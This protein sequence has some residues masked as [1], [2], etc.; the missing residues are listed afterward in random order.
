MS[1]TVLMHLETFPFHLDTQFIEVQLCTVFSF[2]P[3]KFCEVRSSISNSFL[4]LV[5]CIFSIFSV[6][7]ANDLLIFFIKL[8]YIS[9]MFLFSHLSPF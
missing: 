7:L 5:L 6:S 1:S 9:I 2:N 3:F 4:I 8:L